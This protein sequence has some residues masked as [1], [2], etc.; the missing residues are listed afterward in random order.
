[1]PWTVDDVDRHK[2]GLSPEQ[3]ARWVKIANGVLDACETTSNAQ[4]GYTVGD[5]A[6]NS[7]QKACQVG[8]LL[9]SLSQKLSQVRFF[10][11]S[12]FKM[13]VADTCEDT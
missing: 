5:Y 9:Q 2:A 10:L 13:S 7:I 11:L 3:K 8:Q 12:V 4:F 6:R 1:M